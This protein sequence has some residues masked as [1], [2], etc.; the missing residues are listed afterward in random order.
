MVEA[1]V[2]E[3]KGSMEL[4]L[5][6]I[7]IA[8]KV[9]AWASKKENGRYGINSGIKPTNLAILIVGHSFDN[10]YFINLD[11]SMGAKKS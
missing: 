6:W 10:F 8:R 11:L 4:N 2:E 3:G 5:L 9:Q 7:Q 1:P